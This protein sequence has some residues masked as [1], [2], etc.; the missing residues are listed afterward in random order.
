VSR[1]E[2]VVDYSDRNKNAYWCHAMKLL[3]HLLS[4]WY[5]LYMPDQKLQT[6]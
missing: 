6:F 3:G 5:T 1:E 2:V 4:L